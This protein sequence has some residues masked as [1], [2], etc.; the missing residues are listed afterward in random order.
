MDGIVEFIREDDI[1][2]LRVVLM[3]WTQFNPTW[4]SLKKDIFS[5]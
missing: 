4:I 2:K 1:R 3:K 5:K